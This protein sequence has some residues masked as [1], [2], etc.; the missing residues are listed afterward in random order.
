MAF[1]AQSIRARL[2]FWYTVLVLSTLLAFGA[3]SYYFTG[4]TLS[5][6]LDI[7]LK[8]E[9]RWVKDFIQPKASKVRPGKRSIESLLRRTPL[10]QKVT[11][12]TTDSEAATEEAD[13]IWNQ[14]YEHTMLGPKKTYIQVADRRGN[15]IH[16]SIN[17]GLDSLD[18]RYDAVA[19]NATALMT[20]QLA[21]V[22]SV[23]IAAA[24]DKNFT[25]LV[26]YPLAELS[27]VLENLYFIFVI[28]IP[29]AL[30]VSVLGGFYLAKKSLHPVDEVTTRA[31]RITAE[32]L[33]QI[34]PERNVNDEIG[35]L[36]ATINDMILR[37]HSSFA[38]IR[39]FSADASHELRTPL[40]IMRGEIELSLRS[41]KTEEEYRRVLESSLEEI[42]RMT[43]IIEN[44]LLLAK[45]DQGLYEVNFTEVNMASLVRELLDDSEILAEPKRIHVELKQDMPITLVGD[46]VRLRQLF[47]NLIDNAIKYTPEGGA[48]TLSLERQNSMALFRVED[49]GIGI[50]AQ[51]IDRVFD[52]FYRVDKARSREWGGAGLGLSIAKWIAEL[53]R[54]TITVQS[55]T[56]KGS[57][58]TVHLPIN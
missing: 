34:I 25:I 8:N 36:I 58:F 40:T 23:R 21:G 27:E 41:N 12:D 6:N 31:R 16:R 9:V 47:L 15:L 52:R 20:T 35:R 50:P 26:G 49:T 33:D 5:D 43:S 3:V 29:I 10:P 53:H 48:V 45:A 19:V 17:L 1:W 51:E 30:T 37:L 13:E 2:T 42:L 32:N 4:R 28:L 22:G 11:T 39:Q 7:S 55:E 18:V 56:N 14:I 38:Q 54:G 24:R 46:K 44:L 57:T